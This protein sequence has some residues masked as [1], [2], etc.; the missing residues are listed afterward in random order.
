M[1]GGEVVVYILGGLALVALCRQPPTA[2]D[3]ALAAHAAVLARGVSTR[4]V[5]RV[6]RAHLERVQDD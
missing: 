3:A 5:R 1:W 6:D 2:L 4:Y